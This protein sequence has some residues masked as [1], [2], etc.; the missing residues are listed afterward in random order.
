MRVVAYNC[1]INVFFIEALDL[2]HHSN[3]PIEYIGLTLATQSLPP[4]IRPHQSFAVV[5][6]GP[7]N[8]RSVVLAI[9]I[10]ID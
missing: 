6:H 1:A 4:D 10:N 5:R 8:G 2:V 3:Q 9:V 7:L